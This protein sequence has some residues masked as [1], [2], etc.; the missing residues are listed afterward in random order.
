MVPLER[1]PQGGPTAHHQYTATPVTHGST[2]RSPEAPSRGLY[3]HAGCR[4][5]STLTPSAKK[6]EALVTLLRR[7]CFP[8]VHLTR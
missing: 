3:S 8:P 6:A 7:L 4:T 5:Q 2:P 1:M